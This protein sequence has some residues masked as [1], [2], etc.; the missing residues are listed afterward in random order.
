MRETVTSQSCDKADPTRVRSATPPKRD[1]TKMLA[2][3][4]NKSL[5]VLALAGLAQAQSLLSVSVP[6]FAD[7][8]TLFILP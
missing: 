1:D 4:L 3:T 2:R 5:S 8:D 7:A 6:S